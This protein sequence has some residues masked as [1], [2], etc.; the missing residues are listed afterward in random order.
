MPESHSNEGDGFVNDHIAGDEEPIR[1]LH[2]LQSLMMQPIG[3]IR[4]SKER[5][6][7]YENGRAERMDG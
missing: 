2:I 3:L 4:E 7:V 1:G 5:R 6:G